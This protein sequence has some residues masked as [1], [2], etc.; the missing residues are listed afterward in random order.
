MEERSPDMTTLVEPRFTPD[1]VEF[2]VPD[3]FDPPDA[4][5]PRA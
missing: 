2:F 5:S 4:S 3:R 1:H